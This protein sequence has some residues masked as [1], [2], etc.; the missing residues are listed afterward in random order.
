MIQVTIPKNFSDLDLFHSKLKSISSNFLGTSTATL[1]N[2]INVLY[3][4]TP[5][6]EDLTNLTTAITYTVTQEKLQ[7]IVSDAIAFGN[8]LTTAFAAENISLGITVENK[9]GEI[10][11]KLQNV[12]VSVQAG[13]L[14]EAIA[15]LR[16]IP[17]ENYD[18]KYITATRVLKFINNLE[19]Y[20]NI[21]LS[22]SI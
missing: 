7:A 18:A 2:T 15:R 17:Q 3:N 5:S 13:S 9:T 8:K 20:L 12:L 6:S 11:D 19:T 22:N 16:A 1:S 21:P 4:T 10:L 14:Y